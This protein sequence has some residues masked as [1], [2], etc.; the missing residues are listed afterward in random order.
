MYHKALLIPINDKRQIFIQD[1]RNYKKPDWGFFGGSIEE[2]EEPIEAVI[3]ETF[4]ELNIT[5][6][7]QE[8]LFVGTFTVNFGD[9]VSRRHC[10]VYVTEQAEFTVSEGNG[11]V[12]LT[13]KEATARL[14]PGEKFSELWLAIE[15]VLISKYGT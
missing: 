11:G 10:Y 9:I 3:R 14:D 1:R 2:N 5:I 7:P 15:K 4:E 6:T 13:E 8:L 12:W